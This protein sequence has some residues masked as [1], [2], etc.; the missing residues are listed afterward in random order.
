MCRACAESPLAAILCRG[1]IAQYLGQLALFESLQAEQLAE[2]AK[3]SRQL[4]L[5][6]GS[7][8]FRQGEEAQRVFV[9]VEGQVALERLATNG[10]E[11]IVAIVGPG[12]TL[13]EE[14][15]FEVASLRDVGARATVDCLLVGIERAAFRR[16]V[17][18]SGDL[19][20]WLLQTVHGRQR[21]LID[22][23]ERLSM[24]DASGRLVDFLLSRTTSEGGVQCIELP[25]AKRDLAAH[26]AIQPE[27][28]SRVLARMKRQGVLRTDGRTMLVDTNGLRSHLDCHDCEFNCW[29]CPRAQP[30][31]EVAQETHPAGTRLPTTH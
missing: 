22:H 12:E 19:A 23:I 27:T 14:M 25:F 18:E 4:E 10:R 29:G 20:R 5:D 3:R 2:V 16:L 17:E 11:A 26:L 9:V 6:A 8:L 30:A 31:P 1:S 7:W 15:L 21:L 24:H 13:G 28:L